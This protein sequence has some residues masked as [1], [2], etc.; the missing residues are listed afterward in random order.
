MIREDQIKDEVLKQVVGHM[1]IAAR[2]APKGRGI[3]NLIL[4]I[5]EK[6]DLKRIA[7]KMTEIGERLSAPFFMRDA[8]NIMQSAYM[9]IFAAKIN[10]IGMDCGWCGLSDC[11][12]KDIS[13]KTPCVF[14]ITD[15]GIAVGSAVSVAADLKVDCRVLY[16][17]GRAVKEMNLLGDEAMVILCVPLSATSKS[18]F[19]DRV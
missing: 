7:D 19:F 16:S 14:N 17:A 1:L 11:K 10:S 4:T 6:P 15:L 8:A 13:P 3:D 9:L 5:A 12:Q 18:P 2:T